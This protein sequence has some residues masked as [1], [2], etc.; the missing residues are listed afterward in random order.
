[1][2]EEDPFV[3]IAMKA[4]ADILGGNLKIKRGAPLLYN[5]AVD[6]NLKLTVKPKEPKR[7]QSA[8]QTD[9][10][11]FECRDDGIEIPRVVIEFKKRITTHDVLTYSTKAG[12]H[13]QVYP[14]LRYGIMIS[15]EIEIP[16]RVYSHN[17]FLDFVV[18]SGGIESHRLH[19]L[20]ENILKKEI[21]DSRALEEIYF[22]NAGAYIYRRGIEIEKGTG[23]LF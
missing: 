22:G 21:K 17:E 1:M 8:F 10:C 13:K 6:N 15:S 16:R 4:A 9:L 23:K 12:K 20:F 3:E 19:Q 11:V 7:G 5:V 14:Y 18:C 2:A